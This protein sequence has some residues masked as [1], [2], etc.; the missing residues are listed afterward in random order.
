MGWVGPG[1]PGHMSGRQATMWHCWAPI[2]ALDYGLGSWWTVGHGS[3]GRRQDPEWT[4]STPLLS[5]AHG[6]LH[7]W[8]DTSTGRIHSA[9]HWC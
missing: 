6:G 8:D 9:T 4:A 5:L 1:Q 7:A 3:M 2:R